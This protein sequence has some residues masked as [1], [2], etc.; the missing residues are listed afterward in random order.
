MDRNLPHF[1]PTFK[2]NPS[3]CY[4]MVLKIGHRGAMGYAPENTISSVKKAL[5]L[6]VD[7]IELDV[8]TCKTG[9]L[10]VFHDEHLGIRTNGVG[11]LLDKT[12][13]QIRQFLVHNKEKIPTLKEVFEVVKG[14]VPL[15]LD[16]KNKNIARKLVTLIARYDM[17]DKVIISSFRKRVLQEVKALHPDI[18]TSL[19]VYF[20]PWN[21]GRLVRQYRISMI[22]P[23]K[24][25]ISKA[26]LDEAKAL[27]LAVYVWTLN[28]DEEIK[29]HKELGV[30]GII[31]DY[32]DRV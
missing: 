7:M 24:R 21:L 5:E 14:K 10:L 32:P 3:F 13:N 29:Q 16:V 15:I 30:D 12:Y 17:E 8:V 20:K 2:Y 6:G 18:K 9:E 26:F 4:A 22:Q 31:S 1:A 25:L 19:P 28:E 27:D 23:H 11:L